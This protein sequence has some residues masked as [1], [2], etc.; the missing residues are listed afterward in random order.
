MRRFIAGRTTAHHGPGAEAITYAFEKLLG[1]SATA[2]RRLLDDWFFYKRL[3][4]E[5]W[6]KGGASH[7][8]LLDAQAVGAYLKDCSRGIVIATIHLGDYLEGLRQLLGWI[9]QK[10]VFVVRRKA[11]SE[12]EQRAFA[13][14]AP[15]GLAWTVL[16]TGSGAAATAVRELRRGHVLI[17]F[18]DLPRDF[19]PTVEVDFFGRRA[20]FVR[21]P[22]EV[23]LLGAADVLAVFTHYEASGRSVVEAMPVIAARPCPRELRERQAVDVSQQLCRWAQQRIGRYPAQWAN[24]LWIRELMMGSDQRDRAVAAMSPESKIV[25]TQ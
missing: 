1:E 11:W 4:N 21:G 18:F 23:A 19:G 20:H 5:S 16:R 24:W 10:Q 3:E 14:I 2:A 13:R 8:R 6:S 17:L 22:A 25:K 9:G 12:L 15:K 7:G